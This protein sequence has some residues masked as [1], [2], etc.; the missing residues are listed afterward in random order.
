MHEFYG[1][2][3]NTS[4]IVS[5]RG[6]H[7]ILCIPRLIALENVAFLLHIREFMRKIALA[8]TTNSPQLAEIGRHIRQLREARGLSRAR[9]AQAL[10]VDPTSI[11]GWESGHRLPRLD[12]RLKLAELLKVDISSLFPLQ[13]DAVPPLAATLIDTH[14]NLPAMLLRLANAATTRLRALR[15]AAPYAT[16]GHVQLPWRNLISERLLKRTIAVQ[17]IEIIYTPRRLQERGGRPKLNS[18]I[19]GFPT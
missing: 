11:S 10:H 9:V 18:P 3:S 1:P 4:R 5:G 2:N 17:R 14:T 16:P 19:S 7:T 12:M 6:R 15:L 8:Q 13:V